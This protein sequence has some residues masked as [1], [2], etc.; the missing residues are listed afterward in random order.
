MDFVGLASEVT[1]KLQLVSWYQ[2]YQ[3]YCKNIE[4]NNINIS[5]GS[6]W[7]LGLLYSPMWRYQEQIPELPKLILF[8]HSGQFLRS[9]AA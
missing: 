3:L 9:G 2:I 8:T 5:A 6:N 7:F 4:K 1:Q